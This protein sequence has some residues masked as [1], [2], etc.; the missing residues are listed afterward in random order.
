VGFADGGI[1]RVVD[2]GLIAAESIAFGEVGR[3]GCAARRE[4]PRLIVA[5]SSEGIVVWSRRASNLVSF[6]ARTGSVT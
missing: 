3:A 6:K 1:A 4:D 5:K 2:E